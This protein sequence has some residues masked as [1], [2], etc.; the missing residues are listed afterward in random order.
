MKV[1]LIQF[2]ATSSKE[3]N[4]LRASTSI[5]KAAKAGA[6]LVLL[7]EIFNYRRDSR[8]KAQVSSARETI[9]GPTTKVF[10]Q[11]AAK[12]KIHILLGSIWEKAAGRKAFNSS[13]LL[14][15]Q[16]KILAKYR[17]IHLFD[18]RLGDTII[19]EAD[20]FC[21]GTKGA[22]ATV[23]GWKVALSVCYDLRF[24]DMYR[25]YAQKGAD[26]ILIPSCFTKTT[27]QAH[28]EVLLRA[29]AIENLSY[30]LAPNQVGSDKRGVMAYGNSMAIGPWGDVMIRASA[31]KEEIVYAQLN[32]AVVKQARRKLPGIIK[33][34]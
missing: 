2:N 11:L 26:I 18:A 28:W 4:V 7:P 10:G 25:D 1:A 20:C 21:P 24:P 31:D 14:N 15:D 30:V 3:D 29:R 16:G 22:M 34:D 17:K 6:K 5:I 19:Q 9:P 33:K 13:V 23:N 8:N 12:Y 32:R 27:G